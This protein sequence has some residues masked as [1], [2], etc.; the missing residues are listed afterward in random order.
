[1]GGRNGLRVRSAIICTVLLGLFASIAL[2]AASRQVARPASGVFVEPRCEGKPA[3]VSGTRR[4]DDLVG[5]AG[6]D[7]IAGLG[8]SDRIRGRGGDD[9]LC[10]GTG[11][12]RLSGDRG[13][14]RLFGDRGD[15]RLNGGADLDRCRGG[16]GRD[17]VSGC[18]S[19]PAV[20]DEALPAPAAAQPNLPPRATDVLGSTDEDTPVSI[21][22]LASASDP[23]GDAISLAS[24]DASGATAQVE[25]SVGG[26]AR[27]D[28]SGRFDSL[29]T[30]ESA[31]DSFGY[32]VADAHGHS[33]QA[34]VTVTVTGVDDPPVAVDDSVAREQ[35]DAA[36]PVDVLVNDEDP[37]GGPAT[38]ASVGEPEHGTAS[39][40][41]GGLGIAYQPDSGYCNDGEAPDGFTYTLDGG[42]AATVSVT[43]A[44]V[45]T[46]SASP[47]LLPSFDPQVS[48]YVVRC[49]GTPVELAGRTAAGASVS[50]DGAA[51][52][53][54]PFE[55]DVPID[56][57]EAFSLVVD[58][59]GQVSTHHVRCLAEGFPV[60]NFDRLLQPAHEF[61]AVTPLS[62]AG[63]QLYAIV[64]NDDGVPVWWYP[65]PRPVDA[66]VFADG[67]IAWWSQLP[68][69]D[70]YEIRNLNGEVLRVVR[71]V[72]A[73]TD[74]HE[75]QPDQ[76]G[77][78]LITAYHP[79]S[80]VDLTAFGGGADDTVI[81]ALVQE[82]D[83]AGNA[84]WEWSSGDHIGLAETGRWWP[85]ALKN[86]ARDI[87][88]INAVE[89][90]G[91]EAVL[92]SLRHTDAVYKVDKASGEV[93]WKLG[94][95]WTPK[96]L[97]VLNDPEGAYPLGGP[98][99]VRLLA[100][101]TITIHDNDTGFLNPP[102]AVR[103]QINEGAKTATLIEAK[104]D[105]EAPVSPC[106]GS[107][108]RSTDGSW[109]MGWGGNSLVTE[110]DAAGQRTF[111]LGFGGTVFT[112]RAV[113]APDGVLTAAALRAGMDFM[114]PR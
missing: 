49:D 66:K 94:G 43:V 58:E 112:Y 95:T 86:A 96:S 65:G 30:G 26:S 41:D 61:Y 88:H 102:R 7:V 23:D 57:N 20:F 10:G 47:A 35:D 73:N 9:L 107:S 109:L 53:T 98:H 27:F 40:L 97:T 8:G 99:D 3:T 90:V 110:F 44:C 78:F 33:A 59:G 77:D 29:A 37:D 71:T 103:Y 81:D 67:S 74:F 6:P 22:L 52:A 12:D 4:D 83:P 113:S 104:T 60:W 69:G 85:T 13:Q 46:V 76:D 100:D 93:V 55:A 70:G 111:R 92:L 106:C 80:H 14:D 105:P 32:V 89:P 11:A 34:T 18:E 72:G 48:D 25:E 2:A 82:I 108:R 45:T 36:T 50:V 62:Q 51:S 21:D 17:T 28:P 79:R 75:L 68:S 24:L 39:V 42:S 91:D 16:K 31:E 15:D 101:G 84:I 56:R 87:V 38:I 1:M 5:T 114:H 63:G 64:F 54:G 19:A